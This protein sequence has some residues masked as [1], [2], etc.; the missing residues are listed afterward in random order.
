MRN[1]QM[2][3]RFKLLQILPRK[4]LEELS[5]HDRPHTLTKGELVTIAATSRWN[6]GDV[7]DEVE[8]IFRLADPEGTSP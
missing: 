4:A 7:H 3:A 1:A 2:S 8:R 5:Q 6:L